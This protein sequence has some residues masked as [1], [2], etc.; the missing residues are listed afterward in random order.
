MFETFK[1]YILAF[2]PIFVAMDALANVPLFIALT[3]GLSSKRRHRVIVKSI[4]TAGIL[5]I[6]FM[7]IGRLIFKVLGITNS[8]FQIA[9]GILLFVIAG[10]MLLVGKTK[11]AFSSGS[12]KDISVFPLGTPLITGPAV[13]TMTLMI[14]DKY[15]IV[16][17]FTALVLNLFI[18]AVSFRFSDFIIKVMGYDGSQAFSKIADI[19]LAAI[20]VMLVREGILGLM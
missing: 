14:L 5:A 16:P 17:T 8:D 1:I 10:K 12:D 9:G 7:F 2:I 18:C 19:L 6:L 13:L 3:E 20:A 4:S 15:G 11:H